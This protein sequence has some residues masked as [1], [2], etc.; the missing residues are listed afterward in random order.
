VP[1]ISH[2]PTFFPALSHLQE[3][4]D[5]T[6]LPSF[7]ST[8]F[9]YPLTLRLPFL[10]NSLSLG[11]A[12][13]WKVLE[14]IVASTNLEYYESLLWRLLME[15]GITSGFSFEF[16]CTRRGEDLLACMERDGFA[17]VLRRLKNIDR[18][19][20]LMVVLFR[21]MSKHPNHKNS[22]KKLLASLSNEEWIELGVVIYCSLTF[23]ECWSSVLL[24][25][26][27]VLPPKETKLNICIMEV[28]VN[29]GCDDTVRQL[30][31]ITRNDDR[32]EKME[33]FKVEL[34]QKRKIEDSVLEG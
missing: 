11:I 27:R 15:K 23:D 9:S 28:L 8:I 10:E 26:L 13:M 4:I 31:N 33:E 5:G 30:T 19:E 14:M 21:A 6:V 2:I 12:H 20:D 18:T 24:D 1:R 3:T 17:T 22:F 32:N 34:K 16:L 25:R 7:Y 29:K